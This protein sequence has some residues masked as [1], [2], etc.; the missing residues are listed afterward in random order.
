MYSK[1]FHA[2]A[3]RTIT[4]RLQAEL[5]DPAAV[6]SLSG[7]VGVGLFQ[8]C[9]V[10]DS[11]I[12]PQVIG[13]IGKAGSPE[14]TVSLA[15]LQDKCTLSIEVGADFVYYLRLRISSGTNAVH[16]SYSVQG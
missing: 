13:R 8:C 9:R 16:L 5:D 3:L 10:T 11:E 4:I 2:S 6:P 15:T 1:T 12:I 7:T 14:E